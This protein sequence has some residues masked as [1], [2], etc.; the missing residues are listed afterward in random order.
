MKRK[1]RGAVATGA[2]RTIG[3][4]VAAVLGAFAFVV[5][6]GVPAAG[7][8]LPKPSLHWTQTPTVDKH[9]M[10]ND[11]AVHEGVGWAVGVDVD[12]ERPLILRWADGRWTETPQP[13]SSNAV[14]ESVAIAGTDDVWAVGENRADPSSSK[15]LVLHWDG[16][17]WRTVAGPQVPAG[18]FGEVAIG[19]DGAVWAGGWANVEGTEHAV[20]YRYV[21]GTWQPLTAGLEQSIN[22]NALAILAEDDAWVG[23]NAGLAHYDGTRWELVDEVPSDG[24]HIPT[25]LAVAGPKDIWVVGVEH[26]S[27]GEL[28]LALHYDGVS[29]T[30]VSVAGWS[31]QLYDVALRGGRPLAVGERFMRMGDVVVAKPL[32]LEY[33]G[34]VFVGAPRPTETE[35]TLTAVDVSGDR[36]WSAGLVISDSG[37]FVP[38]VA[39]ATS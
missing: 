24:S 15:P 18:S 33:N 12:E 1:D 6:I 22:A 13:V 5:A 37:D 28:P 25:A 23:L 11:V 3:R 30:R 14:L 17:R 2:A 39:Y 4:G 21:D 32:V 31:G 19:P 9:A 34:S 29:W 8:W 7:D 27:S 10:L 35:G 36:V 16:R 38:F 20:V 26:S